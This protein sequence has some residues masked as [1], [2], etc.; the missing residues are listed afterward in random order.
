MKTRVGLNAGFELFSA[1]VLV[2]SVYL[3]LSRG[4]NLSDL[5]MVALATAAGWLRLRLEPYGYLTLNPIPVFVALLLSNPYSVPMIGSVASFLSAVLILRLPLKGALR[6]SLPEGFAAFVAAGVFLMFDQVP[7]DVL[8]YVASLGGYVVAR[9]AAEGLA[10]YYTEGILPVQYATGATWRLAANLLFFGAVAYGVHGYLFDQF[11]ILA[12][13]L[14]T[15]ALAEI[16]HPWKLLSEQN[17]VLFASLGMVAQAIDL[18]DPYTAKHSR[19]VADLAVRI[20]RA[21]RLPEREVRKIRIGAL[22]HDIGKVGVSGAIIRK[23]SQ[24][25]PVELHAMRSHPIVSAGI[26]QPIGLLTEAAEIVRHHHEHYDGSGY[27]DG[28][29]SGNIPI[30]S[31]VILVA[32]AFDAMTTDRPYRRGRSKAEAL[33]VLGEH[34]GRQFDETVVGALESILRFV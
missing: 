14:A 4:L 22:M 23:P 12:L 18:K 26:M 7:S 24:L 29:K 9:T 8:R 27:P 2:V 25:E 5:S 1:V 33:K 21:M 3:G 17:D 19:N 31:R 11:G 13:I 15:V 28:L 30:G 10:A 6:R 16:Y 32:D 20:A 34:A